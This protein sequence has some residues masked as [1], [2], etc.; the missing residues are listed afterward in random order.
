MN[1]ENHELLKSRIK[2]LENIVDI[3]CSDGTWNYD[4]YNHGM[5]NGM[6]L[7]LSLMK[8]ENLEFLNPPKVWV[9]DIPINDNEG[10]TNENIGC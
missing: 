8:S 7:A 5:A 6:I 10:K 3:Q 4:P 9:Y 1:H 2:E